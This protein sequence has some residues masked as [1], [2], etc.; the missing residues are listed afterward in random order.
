[1]NNA[2]L[3]NQTS[4]EVEYY[5]DPKII[6][7]ARLVMGSIQLDPASSALANRNVGARQ[8]FGR[9]Y[10]GSWKD[11]FKIEWRAKTL[12]MNH[13]FTR[14]ERE[15]GPD[16]KKHLETP[17]HKHHSVYWYGNRKWIE[18]FVISQRHGYVETAMCITYAATSEEWFQPLMQ[19]PQCF[20]SP[21]TN[22][23]LPDGTIKKG[24]TK[25]SVVTYLGK[26]LPAFAEHFK[27]FGTIKVR[28][29]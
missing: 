8:F 24:V 28:Y 4:G 18:K 29:P 19:F 3:I 2:Q 25:G 6:A 10:D 26:D 20:L 5:T 16:C 1:M 14:E 23:F 9:Q 27:K 22:Y 21:R 17:S 15:C 13:P 11:G 7:A 12:W